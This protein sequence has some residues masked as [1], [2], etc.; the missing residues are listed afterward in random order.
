MF[1]NLSF[2]AVKKVID[3][4]MHADI[5]TTVLDSFVIDFRI[6]VEVRSDHFLKLKSFVTIVIC[7]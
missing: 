2:N 7:A 1:Y 4:I 5:E 6:K 3:N